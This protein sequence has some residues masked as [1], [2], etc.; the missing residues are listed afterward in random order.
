VAGERKQG[1]REGGETLCVDKDTSEPGAEGCAATRVRRGV[2]D[3][4]VGKGSR[5]REICR[6]HVV[7]EASGEDTGARRAPMSPATVMI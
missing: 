3:V 4:H 6:T 2:V 5:E 1:V 7:K